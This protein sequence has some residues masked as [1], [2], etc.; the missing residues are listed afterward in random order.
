M[1]KR[2]LRAGVDQAPPFLQGFS[3][4]DANTPTELTDSLCLVTA[5]CRNTCPPRTLHFPFPVLTGL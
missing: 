2:L 4:S 5:Q 3:S 1:M